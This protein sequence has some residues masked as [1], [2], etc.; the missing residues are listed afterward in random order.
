MPN[1]YFQFKQ[2]KIRQV[3]SAMKVC[4]DSCLFGA[5]VADKIEQKIIQPK[6]ILDIGAGTGLLSLMVAQKSEAI[7]DAVEIDEG[8]FIQTNENFLESA[9]SQRLQVFHTDIKRWNAPDKYDFIVSNPPY[10]END[11]R[12][13]NKNKN[14]AKHHDG[15]TFEELLCSIKEM[16]V[17]DGNFAVIIPYR[18]ITFFKLLATQNNF[19]L[20]EELLIKQTPGHSYFRTILFFGTKPAMVTTREFIIKNPSKN[21]TVDFILLLKDYYLNL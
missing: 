9:W 20:K 4:T 10:F 8:S 13:E 16:L 5:Y 12:S 2:F 19:Y 15:L 1:D 21:Y 18:R 14:L 11:L 3:K 17:A 7:I 6:R